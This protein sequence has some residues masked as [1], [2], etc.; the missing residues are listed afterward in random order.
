MT[1][2]AV[3][4]GQVIFSQL[5]SQATGNLKRALNLLRNRKMAQD[6]ERIED[7]L[8]FKRIEEAVKEHWE[9]IGLRELIHDEVSKNSPTG[10]VE[11]PPTLNGEPHLGHL[12]GRIMKDLW[13]RFSTLK[14]LNII[15]RAGWDTQGLPVELQ[16]EKELGLTGSK[17]EN[18][19]R[20]GEEALVR[21]SKKLVTRYHEKWRQADELLGISLDQEKAYWTHKDEFIE[22]EWKYLEIAWKRGILK[23]GN[24]VV[25]YC[26]NCQT[27]LSHSEVALKYEKVHDPS[28]YFKVKLLEEKEPYLIVWTTMPFTLVTDMMIGVNPKAN[29]CYIK[30]DDGKRWIIGEE[31]VPEIMKMLRI[32]DYSIERVVAGSTF[33]GKRYVHPL[34]KKHIPALQDLAEKG[35]AHIVVAEAFVE[36]NTGTGIVHLA[37]ANG[38]ID[39]EVGKRRH[40]P[41]F[42]PIDSL[43]RFTPEAGS[44]QGLFVRDADALVSELLEKEGMIVKLGSIFH[45]Y[46]LCWRSGHRLCWITRR[47]YFY[48]VDR[49][50]QDAVEAAEKARYYYDA[51]R[52]RFLEIV[53]EKVPWCISRDRVWGTPLPIWH[54][55]SCDERFGA[56]SRKEIVENA[57]SLPDGAHFELHKPWIDRIILRCPE[58]GNKSKR[59]PF[60]LDTWH[61][62]GAAPYAAFSDSEYQNLFPVAFLT[63]G[64]DQTRGWAYTLLVTNVILT[65]KAQAPFRSFLFQGHV[66]DK[67]GNKMSKKEGNI[68]EGIPVLQTHSVDL[69]RFYL[70]RKSSPAESLSFSLDEMR[71]RPFQVLSTL[72]HLHKYFQQNSEYDHFDRDNHTVSWAKEKNLLKSHEDWLLSK[73][74]ELI[75]VVSQG[76]EDGRYNDSAVLLESFIIE[77]LSQS[78]VPLTRGEIWSDEK[79]SLERR[80]AIYAVLLISLEKV[81]ILLHPISPFLTEY[82]FLKL[83]RTKSI[84]LHTWP[85]PDEQLRNPELERDQEVIETLVS[86]SNAARNKA[87]LKRRWPLSKATFL[88]DRTTLERAK[89]Q[90]GQLRER[91]NVKELTLTTRIEEI[92]LM[93]KATLRMKQVF[94]LLGNLGLKS[95]HGDL[96][97]KF[98]LMT[99]LQILNVVNQNG[100]VEFTIDLHKI[101]LTRD[102]IDFEFYSDSGYAVA[103]R[104]GIVA[105]IETRRDTGLVAEGLVRDVARRLQSLRK[106]LGLNPTEILGTAYIDGLDP[107]AKELILPKRPELAY[108]VRVKTVYLT[109]IL[110]PGMKWYDADIDG[111]PIKI[112]IK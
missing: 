69:T 68:I 41:I 25:A 100:W 37:P 49:L 8:D 6:P 46:P 27:S 39:F 70:M 54:C 55:G 65:A 40:L 111:R 35:Q 32:E 107:D 106:A 17:V 89:R 22:R 81:D 48:W 87:R 95:S 78:Y 47:E 90:S 28:L 34:A 59:E 1:P 96:R 80:L 11:G 26:P 74:Q 13:Y 77:T 21:A 60:V 82:L 108:L 97:E 3:K 58:C 18:L 61:N 16:A 110:D 67:N 71:G 45:E 2:I 19:K 52:N 20:V 63:E 86:I 42:N 56:F 93:V 15:F 57:L 84:F 73:L 9:A 85:T 33:D 104:S 44:F 4:H 109:G 43:V 72:Y 102:E 62:S 88:L 64:I 12:R 91:I 50:G 29:Y 24:G 66:L 51:P 99:G 14:K 38:E 7:L 98:D 92:N 79:H 76:Y 112:S 30:K 103:E 10:Y 36:T 53:K 94:Q 101:K 5:E 23:E 83:V 31:M 75:E 105:A